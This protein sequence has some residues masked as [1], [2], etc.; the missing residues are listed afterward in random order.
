M[1]G[2]RRWPIWDECPSGSSQGRGLSLF[3][4]GIPCLIISRHHDVFK[5]IVKC[6]RRYQTPL[7]HTEKVRRRS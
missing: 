4:K 7:L 3:A 6:S 5:E 2:N 1:I